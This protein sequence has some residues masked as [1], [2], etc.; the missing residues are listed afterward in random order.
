MLN[1]IKFIIKVKT[2]FDLACETELKEYSFRAGLAKF[3]QKNF[4]LSQVVFFII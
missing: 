3:K 2:L 1:T 4:L